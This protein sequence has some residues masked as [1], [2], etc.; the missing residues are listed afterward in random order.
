MCRYRQL[1]HP[2]HFKAVVCWDMMSA[3]GCARALRM[4]RGE[5]GVNGRKGRERRSEEGRDRYVC[6][7]G[8]VSESRISTVS[9]LIEARIDAFSKDFSKLHDS[10]ICINLRTAPNSTFQL[11]IP[12][13]FG[14]FCK[15]FHYILQF[16]SD[17]LSFTWILIKHSS[18]F[19][20]FHRSRQ[21]LF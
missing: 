13:H 6:M 14:D 15:T 5:A 2:A 18:A 19:Y 9:T 7:Y 8:H 20:E 12:K 11:T 3:E 17:S 10:H 16:L 21:C 4:S 1:Y